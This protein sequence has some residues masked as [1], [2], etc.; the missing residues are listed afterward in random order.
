MGKRK[1]NYHSKKRILFGN[2][3]T[4]KVKTLNITEENNASKNN[5]T[6]SYSIKKLKNPPSF[7]ASDLS[8][9]HYIIINFLILQ[10]LVK[11]ANWSCVECSSKQI[12]VKNIVDKKKGWS[13]KINI[14]CCECGWTKCSYTSKEVNIPGQSGQK[15]HELNV[16]SVMAFREIGKGFENMKTFSRLM[17]MTEPINMKAYNVINDHLLEAYL[18]AADNS[19]SQ[20]AT[21]R[22]EEISEKQKDKRALHFQGKIV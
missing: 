17:N 8:D 18:V 2:Q 20:V 4:K 7:A 15:S 1:T 19:M 12:S 10:E 5:E 13:N 11:T 22:S 16:S 9:D 6:H 14:S 3:Y 21:D